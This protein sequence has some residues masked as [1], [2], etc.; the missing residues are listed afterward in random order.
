MQTSR[1]LRCEQC[2]HE[3]DPQYRFC[4]MCGS[5]LPATQ[6]G[7]ARR[8]GK[9][10]AEDASEQV[11]LSGPS[12]L[13]LADEPTDRVAYLLE[14]ESSGSHGA[15]L[16]VVIVLLL[17]IAFAG[18]HWRWTLREW[19][20][21]AMQR[22]ASTQSQD[23]S[24]KTGPVSTSGSEVAGSVPNATAITE[25][26]PASA[27]NENQAVSPQASANQAPAN[28]APPNEAA[29]NP[30]NSSQTTAG[31]TASSQSSPPQ[32]VTGGAQTQ[33]PENSAAPGK[34]A[35]TQPAQ[36]A[37]QVE[38][39]P[40]NSAAVIPPATPAKST[41]P[42]GKEPVPSGGARSAAPPAAKKSASPENQSAAQSEVP[43][44]DQAQEAEGE[45]YLYG[46][47][48]PAD[49]TRAQRDLLSAGEQGNPK[50]ASVLGTMYATGHCVTRDLPLAYFWFAKAMRED[51]NNP[52]VE[53]DLL[54]VWGQMTPQEREVAVK[55]K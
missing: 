26:P 36:P 22:P 7:S 28:S 51:G 44:P 49:C 17:G 19:A 38:Q 12:F 2:G 50:A 48:V 16:V 1:Q 27:T 4:G 23:A 30:A 21:R 33:L 3:S 35:A 15:R 42:T 41:T 8:T 5:R 29:S 9:V 11:P 31:Q 18:W 25:T 13:G 53:N 39:Q 55:H 43:E 47:G 32:A 37:V 10:L 14:D 24:Y 20:A 40:S 52:R 46:S 45:K 54:L 6:T 34:A